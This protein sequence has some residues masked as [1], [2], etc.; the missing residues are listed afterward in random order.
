MHFH[1]SCLARND[2]HRNHVKTCADRTKIARQRVEIEPT[3]LAQHI[4]LV[5]ID[6]KLRRQILNGFV[7]TDLTRPHVETRDEQ[8]DALDATIG[9]FGMLAA[10]EDYGPS[11]EPEEPRIRAV[12]GWIFGLK[13]PL[14]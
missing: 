7:E 10:L 5:L 9:L 8:D 14:L 1:R 4:A 2:V 3:H 6:R 11:L 13:Y 12:E